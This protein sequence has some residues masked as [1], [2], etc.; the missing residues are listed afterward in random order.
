MEGPCGSKRIRMLCFVFSFFHSLIWLSTVYISILY[1]Y[2]ILIY[3][4]RF[5]FF[6]SYQ[7]MTIIFYQHMV[8][9][10]QFG[11]WSSIAV[12]SP[13]RCATGNGWSLAPD[14]PWMVFK[15]WDVDNGSIHVL[16]GFQ[17]LLTI[18]YIT[19]ITSI[20]HVYLTTLML[21]ILVYIYIYRCSDLYLHVCIYIYICIYIKVL[22]SLTSQCVVRCSDSD[23]FARGEAHV[24]FH[25]DPWPR[26]MKLTKLP[27]NAPRR[28]HF[29]NG[30]VW[31]GAVASMMR[32][33][34]KPNG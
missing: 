33:R 19:S 27:N 6:V 2:C 16:S 20:Y 25:V 9:I 13:V 3:S 23:S 10:S 24:G 8:T 4:Y 31:N 21:L 15:S 7:S 11:P 14:K 17:D 34:G 12:A 22:T 1:V 30:F 18:L 5:W 26:R 32:K 28:P 29:L